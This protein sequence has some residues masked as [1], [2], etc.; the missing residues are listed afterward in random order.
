MLQVP[1][2]GRHDN[3]FDLGGHSLLATQLVSR[4]RRTL[5]IELPLRSLFEMPTIKALAMSIIQ[6]PRSGAGVL[7]AITPLT[8]KDPLP[9]S[10]AQQRLWFIDQLS[11]GDST[12]N[13]AVA[14]Q[15]TGALDLTIL[16]ST[17]NEII[18]RH[19]AL[20]TTFSSVDGQ[21]GLCIADSQVLALQVTDLTGA[22]ST[23][24]HRSIERLLQQEAQTGFDL[25]SGPLIRAHLLRLETS[26]FVAVITMHHIV[27][28]GW[29]MGV[30][31]N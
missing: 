2:V 5:M 6:E 16:A 23:D 18:R 14:L 19:E 29:S 22:S 3:F 8:R 17:F 30:L 25:A 12:Y 7:P 10:F 1:H 24:E 4:M 15:L 27:S 9:L 21:P 31:I 28:D 13:M 11:P 20:R 26:R